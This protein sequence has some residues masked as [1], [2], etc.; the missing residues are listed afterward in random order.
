MLPR[1]LVVENDLATRE[2]LRAIVAGEGFLVDAVSDG[3]LA[4]EM[5]D[6]QTYA[7]ILL[8]IVLPKM[9]GA[10][11][12]EHLHKNTPAVLD[13]VVV[14]TGLDVAEIRKLY[15]GVREALGKPVLPARLRKAVRRFL[16]GSDEAS[17]IIVA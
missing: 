14:V 8:D 11:M 13:S 10:E 6:R 9:S 5:L 16:P 4:L 12:M 17:V 7:L 3:E 15:P 2:A 1:A